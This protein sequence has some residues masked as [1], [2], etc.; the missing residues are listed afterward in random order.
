M[1]F[2]TFP[3][4]F[5]P[6]ESCEYRRPELKSTN[7]PDLEEPVRTAGSNR[8]FPSA[9]RPRARKSS[10]VLLDVEGHQPLNGFDR[11]Q[12]VQEQPWVFE[13]APPGLAH[14]S[15]L[16]SDEL[17]FQSLVTDQ[18]VAEICADEGT[19]LETCLAPRRRHKRVA[20]VGAT[21]KVG[22]TVQSQ[23]KAASGGLVGG[24]V[25]ERGPV[26]CLELWEPSRSGVA[27]ES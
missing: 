9:H 6:P 4:E 13:H 27:C 14:R 12:S 8:N 20:H 5:S 16:S 23:E 18:N 10:I 22:R 3:R 26:S 25:A 19:E 2:Y 1:T 17:P 21:G 24:G 11:V 15:L 7:V